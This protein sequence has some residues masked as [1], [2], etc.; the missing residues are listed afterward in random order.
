MAWHR[1]ANLSNPN[2]NSAAHSVV[3]RFACCH[4]NQVNYRIPASTAYGFDCPDC[5]ICTVMKKEKARLRCGRTRS[6]VGDGTYAL[7]S[8]RPRHCR[9][10]TSLLSAQPSSYQRSAATETN[11]TASWLGSSRCCAPRKRRF[12]ARRRAARLAFNLSIRTSWRCSTT[13]C[14]LPLPRSFCLFGCRRYV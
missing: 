9:L 5:R 12:C 4:I 13:L 8:P 6:R 10:F 11:G 7:R 3:T 2:G 14:A 1:Y